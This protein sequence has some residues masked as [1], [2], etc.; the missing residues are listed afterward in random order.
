MEVFAVAHEYAHFVSEERIPR[1]TGSLDPSQSQQLESFCDEPGLVISRECES[2]RNNF[3]L[4]AGIGALIFFRAIELCESVR[5][6]FVN[7]GL[8]GVR[9]KKNSDSHPSPEE[10]IIAIKLQAC[11]KTAPDQQLEVKQFVDEYDSILVELASAVA[12]AVNSACSQKP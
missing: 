12:A 6:L 1:F 10:R 8:K 9:Q 5:E 3:L 4:F 11:T 7:T 2:A